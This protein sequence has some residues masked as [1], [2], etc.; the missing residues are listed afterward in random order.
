MKFSDCEALVEVTR[1]STVESIHFGAFIVVDS[2]GKVLASRGA[3]DLLTYPRSSMKPFQLMPFLESGG[4]ERFGFT[5]QEIAIMCASHAGTDLH[6]SVLEGMHKKIGISKDDLMCGVHW[7]SDA[8]T[9]QAMRAVGK[10][11]TP[12]RHNCSGKHTGMLAYAQMEGFDKKSYLDPLHPVQVRIKETL[13][14]MLGISPEDLP[15][16]IDGCSAPVYGI[17]LQNMAKAVALLA[18][19]KNLSESRKKACNTITS[20]MTSHPVMIAGPGKFDTVLMTTAAGKVFS[21]GGAEGYHIIGVKPDVLRPGSPGLGIAIKI[22]DGD[23]QGRARAFISLL[24]LK[25][26][27]VLSDQDLE[28]LAFKEKALVKNW[29]GLEVGKLQPAFQINEMGIS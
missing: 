6:V 3:P 5:Q 10:T 16:G 1:G 29:R 28:A 12:F 22:A 4:S 27:G 8:E 15:L 7:P 17:P 11:P 18:D 21:K 25:A 24:L 19:P 14:E 9:R 26:L 23:G 13:A 2:D 20:A